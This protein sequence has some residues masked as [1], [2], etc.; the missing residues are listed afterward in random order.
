MA[1][2]TDLV[3]VWWWAGEGDAVAVQSDRQW[4]ELDSASGVD[5]AGGGTKDP[6]V[7]VVVG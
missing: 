7:G 6:A 4:W 3:G 5:A 2:G 1:S